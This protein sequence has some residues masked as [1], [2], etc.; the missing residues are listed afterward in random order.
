MSRRLSP[1]FTLAEME[2]SGT[3]DRLGID[4]RVMDD[5]V[6]AN[7]VILC[8]KV[9]EPIRDQFGPIRPSS[10]YR[11]L[12]LNRALKSSDKSQHV[13]GQAVD[14]EVAGVDN[15][16]LAR[17]IRDNLEFDQLILEFYTGV[18]DSGWV[19]VSYA[20]KN[21]NQVLTINKDGVFP[22]ILGED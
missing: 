2:K 5:L 8:G 16:Q 20:K 19:H 22:G 21:R 18:P 1:H 13:K 9:L 17:W 7:L 4:N 10:G 3:A 6:L 14:F 15:A 11:C 12:E